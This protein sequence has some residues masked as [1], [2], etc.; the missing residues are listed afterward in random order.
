M[1]VKKNKGHI[2]KNSKRQTCSQS[3]ETKWLMLE[4]Y[5]RSYYQGFTKLVKNLFFICGDYIVK[6]SL[7]IR[8][9]VCSQTCMFF[10]HYHFY[11]WKHGFGEVIQ[12]CSGPKRRSDRQGFD[13]S[14][15]RCTEYFCSN[16]KWLGLTF[17]CLFLT[18]RVGEHGLRRNPERNRK[19][20]MALES[21]DEKMCTFKA[22]FV[23]KSINCSDLSSKCIVLYQRSKSCGR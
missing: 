1:V 19:T 4:K 22:R 14:L 23:I 13:S 9:S 11:H 20:Q 21:K 12:T 15:G 6:N 8:P 5:K 3:Y 16:L 10:K 2:K 18:P 7:E 17:L